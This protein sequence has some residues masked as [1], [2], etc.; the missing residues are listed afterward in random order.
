MIG[1]KGSG[2]VRSCDGFSLE[3]GSPRSPKAKLPDSFKDFP[4]R[5]GVF[6]CTRFLD[7]PDSNYAKTHL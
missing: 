5:I 3:K 6:P 1:P 2:S 4:R 7:S